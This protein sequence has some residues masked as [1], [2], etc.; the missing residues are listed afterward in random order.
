MVSERTES[1][2]FKPRARLLRLLGD[3]LIRDPNIAIFELVKNAY[4]GD[5]SYAKVRMVNVHDRKSGTI[6]VEDDGTGMDWETV[7]GVW[8]EPGTDFRKQ[9]REDER[10][11]SPKFGRLPLG[12]KG[13]GRF[14]AGKLGDKIRLITRAKGQPEIVVDIDWNDFLSHN[15]LSDVR[16]TIKAGEPKVFKDERTGTALVIGSLRDNWSRGMVRNAQRALTSICSPFVE[17][18][19]FTPEL[20]LLPDNG[21][22]EGIIDPQTVIDQALFRATG[23]IWGVRDQGN[24]VSYDYEFK[25]PP[26]MTR[27]NGR[28]ATV[29]GLLLPSP[30]QR[31]RPEDIDDEAV[32][33]IASYEIGDITFALHIFDLD[34]QILSLT[35][36]DRRGISQ[37]LRQNGGIRVYR[38]GMRVYNY[39]EPGDDWLNLS[40]RRVNVPAQRLSNNIV[41]G[42]FSLLLESS[43]DLTEKTNREGFVENAAYRSFRNAVMRAIERIT[44]ERNHDKQR[45][46]NAYSRRNKGL[47][48][49]VDDLRDAIQPGGIASDYTR[50]IDRIEEEYL[51]FRDRLLT[52]AGAGL[53]LTTIIHEVERSIENLKRAVD[54]VVVDENI[55]EMMTNLAEMV[56]SLAY[57]TRR[58]GR[59]MENARRLVEVALINSEYRFKFHSIEMLNLFDMGAADF[60]MRCTRRLV[61]AT[62]MNLIDNSIYWIAQKSPSDGIIY[63]GPSFEFPDGPAI[64][65]ADNGPGFIDPPELMVEAFISNKPDGMGLG[66]HLANE[67]MQAHGGRLHFPEKG[68]ISLPSEMTGA[69]VALVFKGDE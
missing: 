69:V 35:A 42:A 34:P 3:E 20:L 53:A 15:Y 59:S 2:A 7:T 19:T 36:T 12:E 8:L 63:V 33:D 28:R 38:D 41:T 22:L 1:L 43:V 44:V 10:R 14:A 31:L 62:L 24:Y 11:H 56:G 6:T 21:W 45:I 17:T 55:R 54:R 50:Y 5:A 32:F 68:E 47:V 37:F 64:V 39:G 46:R 9:Q 48:E 18:G 13:V 57:L 30:T 52:A 66:L 58:S 29:D 49:A 67:V 26:S 51:A 27:V 4:D 65:V 25:P 61:I 23:R 16:V 40:G 60:Q